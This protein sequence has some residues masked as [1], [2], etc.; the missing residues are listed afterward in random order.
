MFRKKS[1][2][3]AIPTTKTDY[4]YGV[5]VVT[6]AGFFLIRDKCRLRI[7]SQRAMASWSAPLLASSEDAVRH[8]PILRTIGFRDGSLVRDFATGKVYLISRNLKR[9]I[10]SPDVF[11]RLGLN[12]SLIIDASEEEVNI[13]QDG[14]VLS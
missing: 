7:K 12:K 2:E 5:F 6:E 1:K 14:E 11:D 4:P 8:L 9:H 3:S 10:K 13:H